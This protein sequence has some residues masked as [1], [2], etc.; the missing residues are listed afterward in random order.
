MANR[1]FIT[2]EESSAAREIMLKNVFLQLDSRTEEG[3]QGVVLCKKLTPTVYFISS[4]LLFINEN[5]DATLTETF[6]VTCRT[7]IVFLS[8]ESKNEK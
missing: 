4:G 1:I 8:E 5:K 2:Q 7:K 3:D 6:S